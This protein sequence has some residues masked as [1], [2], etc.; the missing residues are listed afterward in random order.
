MMKRIAYLLIVVS[1][2]LFAEIT[3]IAQGDLME[4]LASDIIK[5]HKFSDY[6]KNALVKFYYKGDPQK[7]D[8]ILYGGKDDF[9]KMDLQ[10]EAQ[11]KFQKE[12]N[13]IPS[14]DLTKTYQIKVLANYDRYDF[15]KEIFRF[16]M[17]GSMQIEKARKMF[18][19]KT[20]ENNNNKQ[21][22]LKINEYGSFVTFDNIRQKSRA[23]V[24]RFSLR[25]KKSDARIFDKMNPRKLELDI[26]FK[27]N[28]A[29]NYGKYFP[30]SG[31]RVK[32]NANV[33]YVIVKDPQSDHIYK[34]I[35]I[36]Q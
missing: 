29:S 17:P 12:I 11:K 24:E 34:K 26:V 28:K 9:L 18:N 15:N 3:N 1:S 19:N 23:E 33:L 8:N 27:I 20:P 4:R 16:Y 10:G 32:I 5:K 21:K 30:E 22:T 25:F 14:F 35:N 31:M 2:L 13:N 7:L 36:E 6:E